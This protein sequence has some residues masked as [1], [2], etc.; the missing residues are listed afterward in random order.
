MT[1]EDQRGLTGATMEFET[2]AVETSSGK[3]LGAVTWSFKI[4]YDKKRQ[5][6]YAIPGPIAAHE[7]ASNNATDALALWNKK[8]AKQVKVVP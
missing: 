2:V 7:S 6:H 4:A 8:Y 1:A 5:D 3:V